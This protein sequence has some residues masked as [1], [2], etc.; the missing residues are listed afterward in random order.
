[1]IEKIR[2]ELWDIFVYFVTGVVVILNY[3]FI[4]NIRVLCIINLIN[5][6]NLHSIVMLII[7]LVIPLFVGFLIEPIANVYG[8]TIQKLSRYK[9]IDS[10]KK[11][12]EEQIPLIKQKISSIK[13]NDNIFHYCKNYIT[14]KNIM[15]PSMAYLS[16]FGVYRNISFIFFIN[17]LYCIYLFFS[18]SV[19]YIIL[20][21]V[22]FFLSQLYFYRSLKFS[23][24][25]TQTIYQNYLIAMDDNNQKLNEPN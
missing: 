5:S 9:E 17:S 24:H 3:Y 11:D 2:I 6:L 12:I 20:S 10:W 14:H 16:K 8:N 23:N 1:M 15:N 13:I 19:Y 7:Y 22:L 25:F 18:V 21:L 4:D